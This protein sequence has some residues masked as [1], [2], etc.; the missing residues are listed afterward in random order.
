MVQRGGG[1]S[2][3]HKAGQPAGV[4]QFVGRENLQRDG[5]T[6]R[7]IARAIDN[8][9]AAARGLAL[10]DVA[11]KALTGREHAERLLLH[12]SG[13]AYRVHRALLVDTAN[14]IALAVSDSLLALKI[15]AGVACAW[16][17]ASGPMSSRKLDR[18]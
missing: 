4:G 18:S 3:Q 2:F 5:A 7:C 1:L 11:A 6:E 16:S 14:A 17:L 12:A 13:A 15:V 8:A 10:D 9:H